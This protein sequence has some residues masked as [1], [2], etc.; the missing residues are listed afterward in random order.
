MPAAKFRLER[1]KY[2]VL[3]YY[4]LSNSL[5]HFRCWLYREISITKYFVDPTEFVNKILNCIF[6][7]D[8]KKGNESLEGR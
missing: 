7:I 6:K 3:V 5:Y 8:T 1:K 2:Q 4:L